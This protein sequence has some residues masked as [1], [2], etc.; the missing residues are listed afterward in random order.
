MRVPWMGRFQLIICKLTH[1]K[2]VNA[3]LLLHRTL[4]VGIVSVA[5]NTTRIAPRP[6]CDDRRGGETL[7]HPSSTLR[8]TCR[9]L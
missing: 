1:E 5:S 9:T 7:L 4:D 3:V 8:S 6:I 2:I